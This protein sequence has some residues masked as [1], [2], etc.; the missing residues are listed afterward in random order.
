MVYMV[1]YK[2][3]VITL[4]TTCIR[5]YYVLRKFDNIDWNVRPSNIEVIFL[6]GVKREKVK[7]VKFKN[8]ALFTYTCIYSYRQISIIH[9]TWEK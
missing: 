2:Y 3:N 4:H 8:G 5:I 1:L 6:Y 7:S 9:G